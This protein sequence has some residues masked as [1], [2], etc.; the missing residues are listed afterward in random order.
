M[1]EMS[2]N[3]IKAYNCLRAEHGRLSLIEEENK[4]IIRD[5]LH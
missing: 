5:L 2:K 3:E 1:K 4:V